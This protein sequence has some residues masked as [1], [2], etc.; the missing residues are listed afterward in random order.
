MWQPVMILRICIIINRPFLSH[1]CYLKSVV[2]IGNSSRAFPCQMTGEANSALRCMQCSPGLGHPQSGSSALPHSANPLAH[3][4]GRCWNSPTSLVRTC[5][6]RFVV[7]KHTQR[8]S[9]HTFC[10]WVSGWS[11]Q[12]RIWKSNSRHWIPR[13]KQPKSSRNGNLK[14]HQRPLPIGKTLQKPWCL[15]WVSDLSWFLDSPQKVVV[16]WWRWDY[17]CQLQMLGAAASAPGR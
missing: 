5:Q 9:L 12:W 6:C 8:H 3:R 11:C 15:G 2:A 14:E 1:N 13:S 17:D 10:G 7:P 4:E 16:Q